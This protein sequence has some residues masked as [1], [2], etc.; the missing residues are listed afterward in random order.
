ML[1]VVEVYWRISVKVHTHT[2]TH[3][4][5][6]RVRER[7][8]GVTVQHLTIYTSTNAK[9]NDFFLRFIHFSDD[10]DKYYSRTNCWTVSPIRTATHTHTHTHSIFTV[11]HVQLVFLFSSSPLMSS[12]SMSSD[13][14]GYFNRPHYSESHQLFILKN[15]KHKKGKL[16]I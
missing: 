5:T 2:H 11:K 13:P 16:S 1:F 6:H 14:S 8:R 3:A 7:E 9:S 10:L 15:R 12:S 4:H